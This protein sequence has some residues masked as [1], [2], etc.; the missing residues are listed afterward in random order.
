VG[1]AVFGFAIVGAFG[2]LRFLV[3]YLVG[4]LIGEIFGYDP[5]SERKIY[6]TVGEIMQR[7]TVV[8]VSHRLDICKHVNRVVVMHSGRVVDIGAHEQ[9]INRCELYQ[10]LQASMDR[11][12]MV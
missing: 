3:I 1:L 4:G 8:F 10:S 12:A 11:Y 9:L 5:I 6:Q 7:K 2:N